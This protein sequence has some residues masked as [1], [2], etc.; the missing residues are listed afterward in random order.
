MQF[1]HDSE[2]IVCG[3]AMETEGLQGA[4]LPFQN[5]L[6]R[7]A[8]FYIFSF[9]SIFVISVMALPGLLGQLGT[10]LN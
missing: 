5:Y 6:G 8:L 9:T 2:A 1:F 3:G 4:K 7:T 10:W